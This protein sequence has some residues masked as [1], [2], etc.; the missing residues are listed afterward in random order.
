[1]KNNFT[2]LEKITGDKLEG[3]IATHPIFERES[4]VI[5]GDHVT[6]EA[7]TGCV[8]T[9]P[10]HGMED[11]LIGQEYGLDILSPVDARG[12]YTAEAGEDLKGVHVQ[13]EGNKLIVEKLQAVNALL[14]QEDYFHSYPHC[15]RSKTPIIFRATEQWFCMC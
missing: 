8:H 13:K 2:V 3:T 1:M 7:G 6:L 14:L 15:W 11:Y 10:G 12:C 4:P 9:A 5:L